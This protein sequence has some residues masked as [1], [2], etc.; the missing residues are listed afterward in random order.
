MPR[1]GG[2][3]GGVVNALTDEEHPVPRCGL[4]TLVERLGSL[5]AGRSRC[6][7]GN[8]ARR[9]WRSPCHARARYASDAAG[10]RIAG[11]PLVPAPRRWRLP[12]RHRAQRIRPPPCMRGGESI[13]LWTPWD[14]KPSGHPPE[15][16]APYRSTHP[17]EPRHSEALFIT[18]CR[19]SCD[20]SPTRYDSELS[21][22]FD[23]SKTVCI[24]R[25]HCLAL[26]VDGRTGKLA[27]DEALQF[28]DLRE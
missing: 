4:S 28:L 8:N 17:D 24:R 2:G 15:A 22:V 25:T 6:R 16:F 9:R 3:G 13:R 19:R 27:V 1:R 21:V 7:R 10:F 23:Q 20:E 14:I 11:P 26:L 18:A 12:S 5:R